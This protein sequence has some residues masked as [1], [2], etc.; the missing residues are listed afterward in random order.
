MPVVGVAFPPAAED[1]GGRTYWILIKGAG[2]MA[3]EMGEALAEE[4]DA[5]VLVLGGV[6]GTGAL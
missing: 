2:L 1:S 4:V 5:A 6:T 3:S